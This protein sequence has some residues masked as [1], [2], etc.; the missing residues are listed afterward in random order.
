MKQ[1]ELCFANIEDLDLVSKYQ[2]KNMELCTALELGGLSPDL[3]MVRLAREKYD[4]ELSVLI[5][6]RP[7]NFVYS[8]TEKNYMLAQVKSLI[9]M[10]IDGIVVGALTKDYQVDVDFIKRLIDQSMGV[11]ICFHRA[12]D[13]VEFPLIALDTLVSL[14]IDRVLSSGKKTNAIQGLQTLVEYSNHVGDKIE[15]MAGGGLKFKELEKIISTPEINRFHGSLS[16]LSPSKDPMFGEYLTVDE[17]ELKLVSE[18]FLKM[19]A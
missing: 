18:L 10:E 3:E 12:I 2:I 16:K 6:P 1:F 9:E 4:G 17:N 8:N 7:G 13:S 19:N 5:R 11:K 14:Q 15:I